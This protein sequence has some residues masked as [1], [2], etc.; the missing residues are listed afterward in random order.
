LLLRPP[1]PGDLL[2]LAATLCFALYSVL[3]ERWSSGLPI[4]VELLIQ[5]V[6]A[7]LVLAPLFALTAA[8][9][10]APLAWP[11]VGYAGVLGSVA[12]PLL[13]MAGV[14]QI[15]PT[16]AATYFSLLPLV[17]AALAVALLGEP[18][19]TALVLG[20]LLVVAGVIV[21]ERAAVR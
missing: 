3:L 8:P 16:R 1:N 11:L 4:A 12:A 21:A 18:L 6:A 7:S 9:P 13:W 5:S 14:G 2:M 19:E 10:I 20:G 15:G 17:T